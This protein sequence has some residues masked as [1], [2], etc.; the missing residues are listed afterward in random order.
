MSEM[1]C[2][3]LDE[4]PFSDDICVGSPRLAGDL[5]WQQADSLAVDT[6]HLQRVQGTGD[7]AR[8]AFLA[9]EATQ[10]VPCHEEIVS[11]TIH[12]PWY[13]YS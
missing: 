6:T 3:H 10:C 11:G 2:V 5:L 7:V 13:F 4:G 12:S 8:F 1:D 9:I